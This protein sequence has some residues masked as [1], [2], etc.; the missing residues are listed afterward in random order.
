MAMNLYKKL[1]KRGTNTASHPHDYVLLRKEVDST[2]QYLRNA[3]KLTRKFCDANEKMCNS[4][5]E[6]GEFFMETGR[7]ERSE[8]NECLKRIG[9]FYVDIANVRQNQLINVVFIQPNN[10]YLTEFEEGEKRHKKYL[11]KAQQYKSQEETINSMI[12]NKKDSQKLHQ[13]EEKLKLLEGAR[14]QLFEQAHKYTVEQIVHKQTNHIAE[15]IELTAT[16]R[17]FFSEGF[18]L[19]EDLKPIL[20][21]LQKKAEEKA[22]KLKLKDFHHH[23]VTAIISNNIIVTDVTESEKTNEDVD[24]ESDDE[25]EKSTPH[26]EYIALHDYKAPIDANEIDLKEGD[27]I[28]VYNKDDLDWWLGCTKRQRKIGY[29]PRSYCI[30]KITQKMKIDVTETEALFDYEGDITQGE[31]SFSKGDILQIKD[32]TEDGWWLG[33]NTR[34]KHEGR[35][36]CNYTKAWQEHIR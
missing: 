24:H 1:T 6:L 34:S 7:Q 27:I 14:D 30:S 29:F 12:Q 15:L 21:Q 23:P 32:I 2:E 35:F 25:I 28:Y 19:M 11:K 9:R 20:E 18:M 3:L 22:Q 33:L 8:F 4:L 17:T 36:P 26:E 31:L 10:K 5:R 16:F 13:E